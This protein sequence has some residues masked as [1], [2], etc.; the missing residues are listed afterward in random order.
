MLATVLQGCAGAFVSESVPRTEVGG[1]LNAQ[2]LKEQ[3]PTSDRKRH[4]FC[5]VDHPCMEDAQRVLF[6]VIVENFAK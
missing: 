5:P 3:T 1:S 4:V 6:R 2:D